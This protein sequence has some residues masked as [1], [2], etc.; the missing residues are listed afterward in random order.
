MAVITHS[1]TITNNEI[2]NIMT[3]YLAPENGE[4]DRRMVLIFPA[5]L[6]V[7]DWQIKPVQPAL[8]R[9][10]AVSE[11]VIELVVWVQVLVVIQKDIEQP[12]VFLTMSS[13]FWRFFKPLHV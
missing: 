3:Q 10:F 2:S 4:I 9:Y 11:S 5:E 7:I 8:L 12:V 1:S 13:C 6:S